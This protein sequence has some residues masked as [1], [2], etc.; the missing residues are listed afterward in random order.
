[1]LLELKAEVR[2]MRAEQREMKE[3]IRD[4]RSCSMLVEGDETSDLLPQLPIGAV[5]ELEALDQLL[6]EDTAA[7]KQL[8]SL[9]I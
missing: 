1:M 5:T 7:K 3:Q 8:V 6:L 4:L 2:S 9:F